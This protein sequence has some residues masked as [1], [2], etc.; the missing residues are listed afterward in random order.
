[1]TR[2]VWAVARRPKWLGALASALVV[3]GVFAWLG[4]WQWERSLDSGVVVDRATESV[5]PLR[6]VADPQS[7]ITSNAS[8]RMVSVACEIVAGDDLWVTK[9]QGPEGYSDWLVHHCRLADGSSLAVVSGQST[10]PEGVVVGALALDGSMRVGRYVPTESPQASDFEKGERSS[11]SVAEL[12]NLW[13]EPGPVFGGYLVLERAPEGLETI[14]TQP[15]SL[16]R[17]LNW[18]NVFY[19]AEWVIFAFFA[20]YLWF[21]LVRDEWEREHETG[22]AG[23]Q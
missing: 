19:A 21:R 3:A 23:A 6:E 17:E 11:V 2:S 13:A 15:P 5:V 20:L 14:P 16:E 4:Q 1:M 7:I 8:G 10:Q 22:V 9:R 18:L 12:I